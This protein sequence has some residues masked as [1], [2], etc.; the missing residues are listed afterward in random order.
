MKRWMHKVEVVVD[1]LIPP[2]LVL[3]LIIITLELGFHDLVEHYHLGHWLEIADYFVIAVFVVDLYFKWNQTR[4]VPKFVRKYWLDI[5][6]VFPFFLLFRMFEFFA[7]AF[8]FIVSE[9]AQ[10]V[11]AVLHEGLEIEKEGA[12]VA[13]EAEKFLKEGGRVAREAEKVSKL[14][15]NARLMR[16]LRPILRLPRFFKSI[17][18]ML[19][20]YEKPH[21]GHHVHE[22]V[23]K[24]VK[25]K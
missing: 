7:G 2:C 16:F 17:P 6:A 14:S 15:R 25:K 23:G 5:L 18:K 4:H 19:H 11:Q 12:K 20:F 8:S 10:T 21:G 9:S 3:L 13:R 22:F 24:G 1:K